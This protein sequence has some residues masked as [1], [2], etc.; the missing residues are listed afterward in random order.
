MINL[1]NVVGII[2]AQAAPT[3]TN[4]LWAHQYD[5]GD[6]TKVYIK[7]YDFETSSWKKLIEG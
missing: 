1:G 7:Y 3:K 5:G 6:L 2:K 4:V